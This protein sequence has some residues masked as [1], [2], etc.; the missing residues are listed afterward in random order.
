[1]NVIFDLD[2]TLIDSSEGILASFRELFEVY[3]LPILKD[4]QLK[5]F[6]GPPMEETLSKY[7]PSDRVNEAVNA[8]R[9]IYR[10][11]NIFRNK[12]YPNIEKLLAYLKNRGDKLFIATTKEINSAKA[13]VSNIG[14]CKYFSAIHGANPNKNIKSKTDI[15]NDLFAKNNIDKK[16]TMLIGVTLYDVEGAENV[17]IKVTIVLYGFSERKEFNEKQVLFFANQVDDILKYFKQQ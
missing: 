11:K 3:N 2:G 8:Y 14:L 15:L 13:I 6:I 1:M 10:E 16:D 17:G 5:K 4:T 12:I 9:R 7:L